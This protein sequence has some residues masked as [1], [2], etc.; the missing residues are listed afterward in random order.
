VNENR[1]VLQAQLPKDGNSSV[2]KELEIKWQEMGLEGQH[3]Y[4]LRFESGDLGPVSGSIKQARDTRDE[5]V[6]MG[7][8]GED[9]EEG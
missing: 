6:E 2:D 9:E 1:S 4:Q 5:D 3:P 7:E 8:D